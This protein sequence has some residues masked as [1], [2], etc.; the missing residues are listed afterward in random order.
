MAIGALLRLGRVV[1]AACSLTGNSAG[2]P[3]VILI[4]SAEPAIAVHRNVQVNL[5]ARRT[6]LRRLIAHEGL[7]EHAAVGLRIQLDQEIVQRAREWVSGGREFMQLGI[8]Q[9]KIALP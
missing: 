3:V 6:K 2:L 1:E 5:V 8:F 7:E 9:I 4:E